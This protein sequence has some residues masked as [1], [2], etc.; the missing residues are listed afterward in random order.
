[1]DKRIAIAIDG[2]AAAGKSTVAK[3]VANKLG[4]IYIDTGAMYRSLTLH[5][6]ENNID[7]KDQD[8]LS[9]LLTDTAIELIQKENGQQVLVNGEDV[10][11]EI[12]SER[13]TNQVSH[14]ATHLD[15][16]HE[17]VQRQR[18][19][20]QSSGVVMD[21][22]DVGTHILPKAEL[23]FF[24][25]ATVEERAK[26]RYDENIKKGFD[27]SLEKLK[28]EIKQRD[29]IDSKREVAPLIKAEDAIEL[30][31]TSLSIEEV[32]EAILKEAKIRLQ[33]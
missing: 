11:E 25:I 13:V 2:P 17:M 22:R 30:D 28:E 7:T 14:V 26:R 18:E 24:L 1:M 31:T 23:K 8:G 16:R 12:R 27:T 5:A 32:A 6:L 10:T 4:Y 21:G 9:T 15:V 29:E 19:F 20:A 3:I 33:K